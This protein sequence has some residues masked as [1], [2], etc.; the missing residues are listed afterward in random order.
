MQNSATFDSPNLSNV[1]FN[2]Y[3]ANEAVWGDNFEIGACT[4][5]IEI[6]AVL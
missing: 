3:H 4:W 1:L 2:T 6:D 5:S